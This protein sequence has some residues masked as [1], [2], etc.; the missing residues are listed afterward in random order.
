M[1]A[2]AIILAAAAAAL[3]AGCGGSASTTSVSHHTSASHQPSISAGEVTQICNDVNT[4]LQTAVN[5]G[6][7]RFNAALSADESKANGTTLGLDL[8]NMDN[9]L[10][11]IN[12]LALTNGPPGQPMAIQAVAADCAPY[13][14]TLSEGGGSTITPNSAG[15]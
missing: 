5:Q 10:Q 3:L 7:P 9:D 13:G 15:T 6:M 12:S 14:V 11:E 1:K 4:W 8:T 2:G